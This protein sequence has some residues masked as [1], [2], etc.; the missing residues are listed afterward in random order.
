MIPHGYL[1]HHGILG[2][3]WGVRRYQ[4]PDGSLTA[5]G[6]RRIS[7]MNPDK[8]RNELHKDIRKTRSKQSGWA[9][10]WAWDTTIGKNSKKATNK[11]INDEKEYTKKNKD[12]YRML[13]QIDED[14]INGDITEDEY[15]KKYASYSKKLNY[16]KYNS[17]KVYTKNGVERV[18]EFID[19]YGSDINI[20]YL[21]DLGYSD[22]A[23][24][25]INTRLLESKVKTIYE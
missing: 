1:A 4:N 22:D 15:N 3:K 11:Y 16:S 17:M 5:A 10:Q 13:E 19:G 14:Y 12:T 18:K 9:E 21:K 23:A 6:K 2:Q 8:L 25:Y 24:K 20:G 7:S